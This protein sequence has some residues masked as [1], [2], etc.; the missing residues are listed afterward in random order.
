MLVRAS[1]GSGGGGGSAKCILFGKNKSSSTISNF[2]IADSD[3]L[4]VGTGQVTFKQSCSGYITAR[5][6]ASLSGTC[7]VNRL[8]HGDYSTTSDGDLYEFSANAN[9]TLSFDD[10]YTYGVLSIVIA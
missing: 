5:A 3:Y 8:V 1:S 2:P 4:T 7:T 10:S 9:D 6:T